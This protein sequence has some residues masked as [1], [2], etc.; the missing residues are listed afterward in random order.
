MKLVSPLLKRVVYP[1]LARAGY[2]RRFARKGPAVVTYHGVLP[3]GYRV[4]DPML[5]GSLVNASS[6]RLQIRLLQRHY[7]IIS[8]EQLREW[9]DGKLELPPR[10]VLLTCDDGLQNTLT[11]MLPVL[12]EC[13]VSCLFFVTGASTEETASM[14]WYEELYL[15]F[16]S[17]P[18]HFAFDL[19]EPALTV[20][21]NPSRSK[22]DLWWELVRRLSGYDQETRRGTVEKIRIGLGLSESWK[23]KYLDESAG[24]RRFG[25]LTG[26][27]LRELSAG[28][29]SLGAHT[30]SHPM[31]SQT[32][33]DIARE[34]IGQS[35]TRL[36]R[37]L[38][39]P[40]WALAYPFGDPGSVTAREVRMAEE[41]GFSCAFMNVAGGFGAGTPR[42]AIPRVHVT[43]EMA[44]PEFEAHVSG[45]YQSLR[46]R[47]TR[48][49]PNIGISAR[50]QGVGN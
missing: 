32:S 38:G 44:I 42:F 19:Q 30:L 23:S 24:A 39:S 48:P 22:R 8:P 11:D 29:M 40:V 34:E 5:D 25:L 35:R 4:I 10:A 43:G 37:L 18:D 41:A 12:N 46:R 3:E 33:D 36:E 14:L 15:M 20:E 45:F 50:A 17:A 16:L 1:G 7:Q 2:L 6:L 21:G 27:Q 9:L 49:G 13:G 26:R 47:F 28:G 31:L